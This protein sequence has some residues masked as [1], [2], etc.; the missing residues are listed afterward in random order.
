TTAPGTLFADH[1]RATLDRGLVPGAVGREDVYFKERM[2]QHQNPGRPIELER[3]NG[4]FLLI[5]EQKTADGGTV[6]VS[7]DITDR[8]EVERLKSE[9][10]ATISHE[11][12]TPLTSI[13]G[14]LGLVLAGALGEV[15]E[16]S[17]NMVNVAYR[18][19]DRLIGLVNDILDMEKLESGEMTFNFRTLDISRLVG[20]AVESNSGFAETQR[21][22]FVLG[23]IEENVNVRGDGDRLTQVVSNFLSNAAKFSPDGSVVEIAV[24]RR[25]GVVTVSVA[26]SGP[27]VP[28][29]FESRLFE[30]FSQAD[31]SDSRPKGGS[32]LGLNISKAIIEKHDGSI[33]YKNRSSAGARFYFSLTTI[34]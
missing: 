4:R 21:V 8:K 10:V 1:V 15:P 27:G 3:Q 25:G 14:A 31:G 17:M 33:G 26:D 23:E 30:R 5:S 19:T 16:K 11:L 7:V 29:S 13:K 6:T 20:D 18:N 24:T 9:F 32:G 2:R 28:A 34:R 12:R 22:S